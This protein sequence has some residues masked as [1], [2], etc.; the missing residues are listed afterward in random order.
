[1]LDE[2]ALHV[3]DGGDGSTEPDRT[4]SQEVTQNPAKPDLISSAG[5]V[6]L[7]ASRVAAL[8]VV[9]PIHPDNVTM[10]AFERVWCVATAWPTTASAA[11][12]AS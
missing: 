8:V 4:K 12:L 11:S 1:M 2:V 9:D 3:P 10:V 6:M 7:L 5:R